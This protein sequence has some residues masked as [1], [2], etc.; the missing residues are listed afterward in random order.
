MSG[1]LESSTVGDGDV[2]S[3]S[4]QALEEPAD[5]GVDRPQEPL[6]SIKVVVDGVEGPTVDSVKAT[7]EDD[8]LSRVDDGQRM[9]QCMSGVGQ[10]S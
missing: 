7:T 1:A 2:N 9:V 3:D 8:R 10:S 5:A 6:S 4:R